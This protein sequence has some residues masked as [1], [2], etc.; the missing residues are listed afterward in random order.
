MRKFKGVIKK[1]IGEQ[2]GSSEATKSGSGNG[3]EKGGIPGA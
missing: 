3:R 2:F 1:T